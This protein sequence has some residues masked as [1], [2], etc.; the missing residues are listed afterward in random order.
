MWQPIEHLIF[1]PMSVQPQ[2]ARRFPFAFDRNYRKFT[3]ELEN[4]Y[5]IIWFSSSD[6]C[7]RL[8]LWK[9]KMLFQLSLIDLGWAV[10]D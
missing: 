8:F 2:P 6:L 3:I 5:L 7:F 9:K 10:I 4:Y 1:Q